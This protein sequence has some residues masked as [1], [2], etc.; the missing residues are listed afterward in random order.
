MEKKLKDREND[1]T[2]FQ[3]NEFYN[4]PD[5][6]NTWFDNMDAVYFNA[7][8]PDVPN[9]KIPSTLCSNHPKQAK[10]LQFSLKFQGKYYLTLLQSP[11]SSGIWCTDP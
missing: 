6:S 9:E 2:L 4:F 5:M 7:F 8:F 10:T 11:P 1:D 3:F